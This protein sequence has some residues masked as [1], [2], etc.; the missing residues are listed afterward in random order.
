MQLPVQIESKLKQLR[1]K[2]NSFPALQKVEDT[3]KVPKEYVVLVAGAL[4]LI[5]VFF[6]M[7]AGSLCNVVGFVYPAFKSFQAIESKVR[8][9]D[10]QWLIYW[11]VYAFFSIIEVFVDFLLY[12][13]PFYYA[14]KLAFLLWAML[15][16]TRGAKFLYDSFL[17]DFLKKNESKI[18]AALNDAKRSAATVASEVAGAAAEIS[19][20]GLSASGAFALKNNVDKFNDETKKDD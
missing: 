18:D 4:L 17:R 11:V 20:A 14:F 1:V 8:G 15:P 12:W 5:L 6:G 10:T 2:C 19:S 9:D 7:G 13:I 3:L 16:Q